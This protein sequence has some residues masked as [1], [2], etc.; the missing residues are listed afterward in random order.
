M[1]RLRDEV[2]ILSI[3]IPSRQKEEKQ[4]NTI[5]HGVIRLD[6]QGEFIE[7]SWVS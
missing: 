6:M 4:R 7:R 2:G 1:S 3:G 5:E